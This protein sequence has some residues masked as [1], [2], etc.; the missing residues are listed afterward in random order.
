MESVDKLCRDIEDVLNRSRTV[1]FSSESGK[2]RVINK[3][4]DLVNKYIDNAAPQ[5][6]DRKNG[7]QSIVEGKPKDGQLHSVMT[8]SLSRKADINNKRGPFA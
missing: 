3:I 7:V 1:N 2:T 6:L 5:R 4:R 8:E